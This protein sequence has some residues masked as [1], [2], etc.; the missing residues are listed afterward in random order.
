MSDDDLEE[1][2][3]LEHIQELDLRGTQITDQGLL[4]LQKLKYLR[5]LN[6]SGTQVTDLGMKHLSKIETLLSLQLERTQVTYAALEELDSTLRFAHFCEEK[7]IEDLKALGV[8]VIDLPRFVENIERGGLVLYFQAGGE[9]VHVIVGMNRKLSFTDEEVALLGYLPSLETINFHSVTIGP[10]GFTAMNR[11][12]KL[13]DLT[14]SSTNIT[15]GDLEWISRQTQIKRLSIYNC[16]AIADEGLAHL[17]A[18]TNLRE[19]KI[20]S[21]SGIS[22]EAFSKLIQELPDC[23]SELTGH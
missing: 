21:C 10:G 13:T 6:L 22:Q 7:A 17:R 3:K 2:T 8:Q 18:L 5:K 4:H 23:Q 12:P 20:H 16:N 9:A 19:L 15:D 11:L 14:I 1:L